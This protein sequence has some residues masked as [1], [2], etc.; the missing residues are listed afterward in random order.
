[1][2]AERVERIPPV[3][4]DD[5]VFDMFSPQIAELMRKKG[6]TE[7]ERSHLC[8]LPMTLPTPFDVEVQRTVPRDGLVWFEGRQYGVPFAWVARS[9][10]VRGCP[11]TVEI[12][13]EGKHLKSYPRHTACRRL[14]DQDCYEGEATDRVEAP[15]RLGKIGQ[16]IV[17]PRSWDWEAPRRG[18]DRYGVDPISWTLHFLKK[19]KE[20]VQPCRNQRAPYPPEFRRQMV[21]LVRTG[22]SPESLAKEFEPSGQTIR[23]WVI[24]T[25]RDEGVRRDGPSCPEQEELR[26]L[27]REN[28]QLRI[29]REI[30]A[31]ATAWFAREADSESGPSTSS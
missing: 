10:R 8:P 9:V 24:Q 11:R 3:Y 7:L 16:R 28:K 31:K 22:R 30:L 13:A 5:T 18:V 25:E 26:R 6:V 23:N 4:A 14:I 29:E 12:Y 19:R 1:M 17:L 21:E 27:R 20:D 2:L 15:T